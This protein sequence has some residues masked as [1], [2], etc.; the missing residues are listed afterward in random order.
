MEGYT[1]EIVDF[2]SDKQVVVR[3]L[4]TQEDVD[5][6]IDYIIFNKDFIPPIKINNIYEEFG[7]KSLLQIIIQKSSISSFNSILNNYNIDGGFFIKTINLEKEILY[8][9]NKN[10]LLNRKI[11]QHKINLY[12][13]RENI[14]LSL[15]FFQL[16]EILFYFLLN[17]FILE[18]RLN[19][20]FNKNFII[21]KLI[22]SPIILL[23]QESISDI[24]LW[25][26]IFYSIF[27]TFTFFNYW[28][29]TM[30][31]YNLDFL[32]SFF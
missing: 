28:S 9:K 15:G 30:P 4:P 20:M 19:S 23:T 11:N 21:M 22:I 2:F 18:N 3:K 13:E 29:N 27:F 26:T 25:Y 5:E 12:I 32:F 31:S 8:Y 24:Y 10:R 14:I 17:Y 1:K 6:L 7:N 16:L